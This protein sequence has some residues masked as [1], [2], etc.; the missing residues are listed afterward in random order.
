M[1]HFYSFAAITAQLI[2][3]GVAQSSCTARL[4]PSST[5]VAADGYNVN[6]VA[7]GLLRP[8]SLQFDSRGNLLVVQSSA[9]I[10]NFRLRDNGGTC[11]EVEDE[12]DLIDHPVKSRLNHGIALS[13][14]GKKLYASDRGTVYA[15]DYDAEARRVTS[16]NPEVVVTG[17]ENPGHSTR[18]L[19]YSP[20]SG[21]YLVVV[22]GS[23]GNIDLDCGDI[24]TGHCQMKA[25][26]MGEIPQGGYNFTRDGIRLGWGMR[27]SV[28]IAEHPGTNGIWTVENTIDNIERHG[29]DIHQDNPGEELNFHGS[30]NSTTGLNYG[31]PYCSAAW[32][33]DAI[34]NNTDI[35][36]G[37]EFALDVE[38][39]MKTDDFCARVEAPRLTF[40][41]HT[42]PLDIKFNGTDEAFVSFHG[43]WNRDVPIGYRITRIP[44]QDG[45]PMALRT[46]TEAAINVVTNSDTRKCPDGC[47][48]P[49]GMAFDE[50]GR[51]FFVSDS[52]GEIYVVAKQ[53]STSPPR[54]DKATSVEVS[55]LS[56]ASIALMLWYAM[57]D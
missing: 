44:F 28:G 1:R 10:F 51:L 11:L 40:A 24:S 55:I 43:S 21:G 23:A 54:E 52:T 53:Q 15:W 25:F 47:F 17:L 12:I 49:V 5:P 42:A 56:V 57:G 33:V 35:Q 50:T 8:R 36:V 20:G 45:E 39:D 34:P 32:D 48:R 3:I 26:Q 16:R 13:P 22:R 29:I 2:D 41:P 4:N 31:Y 9:G 6:V 30:I 7:Q 27:N 18:T 19:H 37:T 14:D 46:D 38:S